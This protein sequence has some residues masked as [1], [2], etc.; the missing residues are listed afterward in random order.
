M[1]IGFGESKSTKTMIRKYFM[2]I[3]YENNLKLIQKR[4][5]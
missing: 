1:V 5:D 4:I 3:F 2:V